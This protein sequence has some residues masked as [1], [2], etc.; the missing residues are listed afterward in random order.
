[1]HNV[2]FWH[3]KVKLSMSVYAAI[4][5]GHAVV[6]PTCACS[7]QISY[8]SRLMTIA[9]VNARSC[10]MWYPKMVAVYLAYVRDALAQILALEVP[11]LKYK[12]LLP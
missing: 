5:L 6:T 8:K 7:M 1:M 12:M 4:A 3:V 10:S 2:A 9:A 11:Q